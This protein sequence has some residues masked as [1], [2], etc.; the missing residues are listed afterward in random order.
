MASFAITLIAST[1]ALLPHKVCGWAEPEVATKADFFFAEGDI[2]RGFAKHEEEMSDRR[3]KLMRT[4][5]SDA[6]AAVQID[7]GGDT[8][9]KEWKKSAAPD[10]AEQQQENH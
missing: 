10:F 9:S 7:S 4:R 8:S 1:L 6:K 2:I 3:A 5:T